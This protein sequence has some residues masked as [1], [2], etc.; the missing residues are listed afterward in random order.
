MA[1]ALEVMVVNTYNQILQVDPPRVDPSRKDAPRKDGPRKDGTKDAPR[2]DAAKDGPR[3]GATKDGPRKDGRSE[4]RE[5]AGRVDGGAAIGWED[6]PAPD[7]AARARSS[8]PSWAEE[9]RVTGHRSSLPEA[10]RSGDAAR[11]PSD[12]GVDSGIIDPSAAPRSPSGGG[13]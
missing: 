5:R 2:K 8:R 3:K 7:P 13:S 11:R 4:G 1:L 10:G 6:D 12:P 9:T